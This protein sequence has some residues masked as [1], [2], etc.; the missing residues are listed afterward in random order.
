[1]TAELALAL[2]ILLALTAGLVWLLAVAVAQVRTVDAAR[3]AARAMARG[4]DAGAALALGERVA[5]DGVRLSVRHVGDR[6]VV[7]ARGR[8]SGPGGLFGAIPG[9]TLEA[10]AVALAEEEGGGS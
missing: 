5:P 8:F 6:V 7:R 10:E 2:P 9:A 1:M 4:D 3:E